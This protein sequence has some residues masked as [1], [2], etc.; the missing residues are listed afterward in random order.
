MADPDRLGKYEI[1]SV[2]GKGAMGVV[3]QGYDPHI[4]RTVAIKTVRKDIVDKELTE[5]FTARFKNEARAAGRLHHP[6]IV[7]IYEYGE[8]ESV[9]FIAMEYVDG[10]GLR[11]YLE[12]DVHFEF[13]QLVNIMV[14]LLEALEF[15]H[16]HGVIHRDIKPAN[17][18]MTATGQLKVADF[19]IARIDT[20]ELTMEG[21]VLGTP[22]YMSPEQCTGRPSDHRSD[23][24]SAAVVFYELLAG[25]KPFVGSVEA[26]AYQICQVEPRPPSTVTTLKLPPTVDALLAKALA[27]SPDARFQNAREFRGA[28]GEAFAATGPNAASPDLTLLNLP[29]IPPLPAAQMA[30]DDV[31]LTTAEKE[32]ARYVGPLAKLLVRKASAQTHDVAELYSMLATNIGDPQARRRFIE[33]P[34]ATKVVAPSTSTRTGFWSGIRT[35]AGMATSTGTRSGTR[36]AERSSPDRTRHTHSGSTV[37]PRPLEPAFVDE[38]ASRLAIYLGPIARIVAKKAAQLAKNEDDFVRIVAEHI[39]TQDRRAFLREMGR[40]DD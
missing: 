27:K 7:G 38:T 35:G 20:S 5:Q 4:Q 10:T 6:N 32:L 36:V 33:E 13:G 30:W 29:A 40:G 26:L 3:Y 39:G 25:V 34:H 11:E 2:L 9:A 8:E 37:P 18:I 24:F 14:Q 16:G 15:A 19:G 21:T 28:L 31:V 17:L 12:R 1:K 22:A 23:L